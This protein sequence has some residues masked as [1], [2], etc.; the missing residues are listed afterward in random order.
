MTK[1]IEIDRHQTA[2]FSGNYSAYAEKKAQRMAALEQQYLNQQREIKHQEAVIEKLRSFNR[3]TSIKRAESR[4]KM[5]AKMDRVDRPS[6]AA[7][8]MHIQLEPRIMSGND[9]LSVR[10]LSKSCLLYT[11]RCV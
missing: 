8:A 9:V 2:V 10:D 11:S 3:E 5:L 4:E 7:S 6:E 1:V